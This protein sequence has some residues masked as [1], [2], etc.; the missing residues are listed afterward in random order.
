MRE[1]GGGRTLQR[2]QLTTTIYETLK[3][4]KLIEGHE[5]FYMITGDPDA[6]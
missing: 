1:L 6:G 5:T 2:D 4:G 3:C